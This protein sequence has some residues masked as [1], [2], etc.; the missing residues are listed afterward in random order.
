VPIPAVDNS[1]LKESVNYWE[2]LP[3]NV[4]AASGFPPCG[5]AIDVS[6]AMKQTVE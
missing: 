1:E 3:D 4:Y 2:G 6:A 5:V